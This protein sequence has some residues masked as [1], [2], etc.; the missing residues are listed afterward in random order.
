MVFEPSELRFIP[1]A[2]QQFLPDWANDFHKMV[3]DKVP[4][5]A[6]NRGTG[7]PVTP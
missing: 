4:Q 5:F 6:D 2:G 3:A 7:G 1:N